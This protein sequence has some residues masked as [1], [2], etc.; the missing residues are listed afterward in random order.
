MKSEYL[1]ELENSSD[2]V[3]DEAMVFQGL[4]QVPSL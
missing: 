4:L 1:G 2:A 3:S